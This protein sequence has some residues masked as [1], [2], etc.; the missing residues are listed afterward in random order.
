MDQVF[1]LQGVMSHILNKNRKLY[2]AFV[3]FK[4]AFDSVNHKCLW[5]KLIKSGIGGKM[6]NLIRSIYENVKVKVQ[7]FDGSIT[8]TIACML[9]VMQGESLSPFLFAMY[10]NDMEGH[11][12]EEGTGGVTVGDLKLFLLLYADDAVVLS[13]SASDLQ[14]SLHALN[15]YADKWKLT[16]N[17]T[18]TKIMVFRKGGSLPQNLKF[19]YNDEEL[20][21]VN[22]FT[23]LGVVFTP[24]GVFTAAQK[25]LAGQA[26]KAMFKLMKCFQSF[27]SLKPSVC[28]DLFDKMIR[29]VL[30][31]CSEVWGFHKCPNIE[32]LHVQYCKYILRVKRSTPNDIV[33]GEAR[34]VDMGTLRCVRIVKYWL[35]ILNMRPDRYVY[36][37]YCLLKDDCE[38][39]KTNWVSA[40][41][42][43]LYSC[44]LGEAWAS[45]SVISDVA[46]MSLFRQRLF[47]MYKQNWGARLGSTTR[48]VFYLN[49]NPEIDFLHVSYSHFESVRWS[50]NMYDLIKLH[51][52][53]H[54]L[55][56]ESGRWHKP[57]P[58]ALQDR[59]CILCNVLDDEFHFVLECRQHI[60]LRRKY[61]PHYYYDHPS[62][63]SFVK[64]VTTKD[65]GVVNNL[66]IYTRLAFGERKV[67]S[68]N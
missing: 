68:V 28:F 3:D 36:R 53:S 61:I 56:I 1:V 39:G 5:F 10:L 16:I 9:G 4:Q 63:Y 17:T 64:L 33:L 49:I 42:H 32:Q 13:N 27:V 29:P 50:N 65:Q 47:D 34:R 30:M 58:I 20:E 54:R 21:I 45:Q 11:M 19:Y 23:Y 8:E 55:A 41:K 44:G 35:K 40:L 62:M 38:N 6:L 46:F 59:L 25:T 67:L 22:N 66:A 51:T 15:R 52:S 14:N 48:G 37:I 24:R 26:R 12:R 2:C 60:D 57:Q 18:K 31:Y 7:T 43:V